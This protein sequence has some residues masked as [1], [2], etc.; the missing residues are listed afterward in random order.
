MRQC[1][2]AALRLNPLEFGAGELATLLTL[3]TASLGL[4]PLEFGAGELAF[5][6][7]A[8]IWLAVLIPLSSGQVSWLQ[9]DYSPRNM[10]GLNPLEFGA[11]E[12]AAW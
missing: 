2:N 7:G 10:L 1:T 9:A 4:N 5:V 3:L 8:M 6:A 12:L 11:G